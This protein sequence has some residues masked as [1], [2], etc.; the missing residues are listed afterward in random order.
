MSDDP[1]PFDAHHQ[2]ELEQLVNL[3]LDACRMTRTAFRSWLE[4]LE[5]SRRFEL[6]GYDDVKVEMRQR[7]AKLRPAYRRRPS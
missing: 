5:G 6:E 4:D 1:H 7:E 3:Y 2:G